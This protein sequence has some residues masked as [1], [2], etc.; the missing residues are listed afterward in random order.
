MYV[1]CDMR[2]YENITRMNSGPSS[3]ASLLQCRFSAASVPHLGPLVVD[4]CAGKAPCAEVR[5][6][7]PRHRLPGAS[8]VA[9]FVASFLMHKKHRL[10]GNP[11]NDVYTASDIS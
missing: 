8:G 11:R 10:T 3:L 4:R 2:R 5:R 7:Q 1:I 6:P 9:T